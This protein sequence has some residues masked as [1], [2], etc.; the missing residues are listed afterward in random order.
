M[1]K[2]RRNYLKAAVIL[3]A[4]VSVTS[5]AL[6]QGYAGPVVSPTSLDFGTVP[7]GTTSAAQTLT[8]S[9]PTTRATDGFSLSNFSVTVPTG[10]AR[11]GGTCPSSG[12][13]NTVPCTVDIVFSPTAAGTTAG[14]VV[15]SASVFGGPTLGTAVP[16][17]GIAAQTV[18]AVSAPALG[19]WGLGLLLATLMASGLVFTRKR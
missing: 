9:V 5:S 14:N 15:V 18:S 3:A 1:S 8:V 7:V 17:T 2:A 4:S 13:V 12:N 6:G 19:N 10:Y 11:S 16:V